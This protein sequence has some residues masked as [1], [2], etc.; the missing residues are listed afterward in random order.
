MAEVRPPTIYKQGNPPD[1]TTG[2]PGGQIFPIPWVDDLWVDITAHL[3]KR[4]TSQN[5]YTWV[6]IEGGGG[7]TVNFSDKEIPS[8][9]IDGVNT[10]FTLAN[11]P[12]PSASLELFL[13]G[14]N[15]NGN[16][17][18]SSATITYVVAPSVGDVHVSWYRY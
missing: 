8:G 4:C 13:N 14:V 9:T 17:S 11:I 18:L 2:S 7:P 3:V 1:Q 12:S 6:S 5:P 15:Q 10:T 16:F